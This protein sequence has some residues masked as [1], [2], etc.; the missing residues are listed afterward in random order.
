MNTSSQAIKVGL[1]VLFTA[2][3]AFGAF[4]FV[5]KGIDKRSDFEVWC[6]FRDASG[7]V[8]KSRIQIAGLTIGEISRRELLGSRAKIT[9][10][11]Q[12]GTV[13]YSNAVVYKKA[14]SLLG[15]F[16]LEIDPGSP[17]SP[18]HSGK[19]ADNRVLKHGDQI[20]SVVEAVTVG[21][22]LM[23]IQETLPVLKDILKDVRQI[24]QGPLPEVVSSV[25]TAIDKNSLAAETM[26]KHIDDIALDLRQITAGQS[27]KDIKD[28]IANVKDITQGLKSVL[29]TGKGEID[30]T[31]NKLQTTIDKV[32][33]AVD[34]LDRTLQNTAT[35]TEKVKQGEGT[36]GRLLHDETI[37]N[38]VEGITEDVGSFLKSITKLQTL[39]GLR[40]EYNI[41]SNTL[42]T[43]VSIQ[44][45]ARP[46]KFFY[47]ELIDDPR[48]SRT[49]ERTL[50]TTDDPT[51]PHTVNSETIKVEDKF[52]FTFMLAKRLFL[53]KGHLLLT[54]RFGIKESTGGLGLDVDIPMTMT[55]RWFRN[56]RVTADIFDFR[57]NTYPRL[58]L[59]AAL[60][61]F[62][63][64]WILGGV[65]DVIN[66]RGPGVGNLTGR[67]YFFGV[68]L[69]F[70][71]EDL[72]GLLALGGAALLGG[73][74]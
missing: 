4:K 35:I 38:N 9:I 63:H 62:K 56:L 34:K 22:V 65:D 17:Q 11:L 70:N 1:T 45:Q 57:T 6:L 53:L 26:L 8:D 23:Q 18:D 58:K 64:M 27:Q 41:Q 14:A 43:Y 13:L 3:C 49:T 24:T 59:M 67:D 25:K 19:L 15:E 2:L 16:Y 60:E 7:L 52:R 10:K 48:G 55:S 46:D 54:G 44:L 29:G 73:G 39:I 36:V 61:F 51:K 74:R 69:S 30:S 5:H 31:N 47:V 12:P 40:S 71:D 28:A 72:R 33:A 20:L 21:D 68:M 50:T 32:S 66:N 37:A 42:K